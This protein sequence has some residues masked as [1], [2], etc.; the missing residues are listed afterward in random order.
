[1]S[2]LTCEKKKVN[3]SLYMAAS[4]GVQW[5]YPNARGGSRAVFCSE[6]VR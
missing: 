1:M 2:L 4:A 3:I 6:A 5:R